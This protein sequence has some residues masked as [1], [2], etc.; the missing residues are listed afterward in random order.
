M[1]RTLQDILDHGEEL[2]RRFEDD[3]PE[4]GD[5]RDPAAFIALRQSVLA[6]SAAERAIQEA[7]VVARNQGYSWRTIGTLIGTSGEAARQRY[8]AKAKA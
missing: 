4:A 1:P 5:E 3:T 8:G 2:A 7:V 6:R